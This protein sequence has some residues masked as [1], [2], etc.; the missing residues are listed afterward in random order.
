M[1]T[2]FVTYKKESKTP[3]DRAIT[4]CFLKRNLANKETTQPEK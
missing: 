4:Y 2:H 1:N 3:R